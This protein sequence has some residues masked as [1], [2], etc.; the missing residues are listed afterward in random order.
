MNSNLTG[1]NGKLETLQNI[2]FMTKIINPNNNNP[3]AT[4]SLA[5]LFPK[6]RANYT[7]TFVYA[8]NAD[9]NSNNRQVEKVT[10]RQNGQILLYFNENFD[11]NMRVNF[12]GFLFA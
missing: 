5:E 10:V 1:L 9:E 8:Y 3:A 7:N 11:V 6:Q 12:I 4:L 2:A